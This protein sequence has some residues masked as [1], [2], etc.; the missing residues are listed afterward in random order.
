MDLGKGDDVLWFDMKPDH[1]LSDADKMRG[2]PKLDGGKGQDTLNLR[3]EW[4]LTLS[5]GNV[6]MDTDGDGKADL[7]TNVYSESDIGSIWPIRASCRA[8]SPMG[9]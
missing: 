3:G 1:S 7:V 2:G 5:S 4:T 9:R 8:R 6:T